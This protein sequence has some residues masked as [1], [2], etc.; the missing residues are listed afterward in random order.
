MQDIVSAK[1]YLVIKTSLEFQVSI[2][3]SFIIW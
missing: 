2:H 1:I 3:Y